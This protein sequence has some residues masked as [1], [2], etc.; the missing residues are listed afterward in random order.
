VSIAPGACARVRPE[1]PW[2][3]SEEELR[4]SIT[5]VL[6][7]QVGCVVFDN[8]AEGT[9]IDSAILAQLVTGGVWADRL[10][11][12]S[13]TTAVVNDRLWMAT[14]NTRIELPDGTV[15]Y[16]GRPTNGAA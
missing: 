3:Y 9:V 12:A 13:R 5:A 15:F 1:R 4:K 2:T 10:L 11:G 16:G 8:V 7:D 14:G 6:A